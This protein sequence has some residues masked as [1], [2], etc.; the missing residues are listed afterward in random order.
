MCAPVGHHIQVL[1]VC[2]CVA[3]P[4]SAYVADLG[5]SGIY[6]H[7]SDDAH[8]V[9]PQMITSRS[10]VKTAPKKCDSRCVVYPSAPR[11][12]VQNTS[13]IQNKKSV[14]PILY[15][16]DLCFRW[17]LLPTLPR[18]QACSVTVKPMPTPI[19][20]ACLRCCTPSTQAPRHHR[21]HKPGPNTK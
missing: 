15:Y 16:Y 20:Q 13:R 11:C 12:G 2:T 7:A 8:D 21:H 1:C 5:A 6:V 10:V 14:S 18:T 9:R 17:R 4:E 3:G 19:P